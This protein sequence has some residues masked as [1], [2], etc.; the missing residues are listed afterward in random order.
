MLASP[1]VSIAAPGSPVHVAAA[2]L[3]AM[4]EGDKTIRFAS[5]SGLTW[6][7]AVAACMMEA[8][9]RCSAQHFGNERLH[10]AQ[11]ARVGDDA[12]LPTDLS[13]ISDRQ[14]AGR[15]RWNGRHRGLNRL[16]VRWRADQPLDWVAADPE[17]SSEPAWLPAGFCLLGHT[18]DRRSGLAPAESSGVAAGATREEAAVRAFLELVERDAVAIWW[19]N[20]VR[21]PRLSIRK[22]AEP[23][24]AAYDDWSRRNRRTLVLHDLTHDLRVPATAALAHDADG[25][26]IAFGFGAGESLALAARHAVGELAQCESNLAL[27]KERVSEEGVRGLTIE[28][29]ALLEWVRSARIGDHPH[30][31]GRS[32]RTV[33]TGKAVDL[34]L[35]TCHAIC[36]RHG[37]K[38][39]AIDLTRAEIGV[40]VV[41]V[42]APG[43]RPLRARFAGGRLYDVPV[44]LRWRSRRCAE[45]HLNPIPLMV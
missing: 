43:L 39:I 45:T 3:R 20:R 42:V 17:L 34:D 22:L 26:A 21:R 44:R 24:V 6:G 5:G 25:G 37:L 16:S 15:V 1:P 28:A 18:R 7:E 10:R 41:R 23:L 32:A 13:L 12:I 11:A 19:Y 36:R 14:Y 4:R 27:I 9:E 38:F 8:A 30:L 31:I 40:P 2:R 29:R 33:L 35:A